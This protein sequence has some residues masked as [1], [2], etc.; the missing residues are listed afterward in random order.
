MDFGLFN[1]MLYYN[2]SNGSLIWKVRRGRIKAGSIAGTVDKD[3]YSK[4]MINK[5]Q[6]YH[7]RIAWLLHYG[8]MPESPIDHI[9]TDKLDNRICNLRL[10]SHKENCRNKRLYANNTTGFKGVCWSKLS[11]K[12]TS[13]ICVNGKSIHLGYFNE[14]SEAHD[15]YCKAAEKHFGKYARFK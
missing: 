5:K 2:P 4:V 10:V 1:E 14:P 8:Y 11:Q 7:H 3:G 15:A 13:S 9:N 6:Y 12:Y